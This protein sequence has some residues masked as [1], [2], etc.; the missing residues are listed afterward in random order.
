[1]FLV[2]TWRVAPTV[3]LSLLREAQSE[4]AGHQEEQGSED[5]HDE[6]WAEE[7]QLLANRNEGQRNAAQ[8]D[9]N[10][11]DADPP[12]SLGRAFG[13]EWAKEDHESRHAVEER[14][15]NLL[16]RVH[17]A[18]A[19]DGNRKE[20]NR[21]EPLEG[22]LPGGEELLSQSHRNA[23]RDQ[24]GDGQHVGRSQ[25]SQ[26][27]EDQQQAGD[28][29]DQEAHHVIDVVQGFALAPHNLKV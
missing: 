9:Q 3:M 6:T 17:A 27:E 22:L 12:K 8:A 5:Q 2:Q 26:A 4:R 11:A 28:Q 21:R 10:A 24:A 16:E 14:D 23:E 25:N 20:T 18:D 7:Q 19:G 13:I 1:M 29:Q 15:G